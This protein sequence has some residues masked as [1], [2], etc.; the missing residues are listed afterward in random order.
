MEP[1]P[2]VQVP[3][4]DT[5]PVGG[6]NPA[7]PGPPAA[8]PID[9]A[10]PGAVTAAAIVMIVLGVVI[11]LLG[12]LIILSGALIGGAGGGILGNRIADLPAGIGSFLVA[13]GVIVVA[14]GVLDVLSG[15]YILPGRS[16]ARILA[17]IL[18]ALG[19]LLAVAGVFSAE[20]SGAVIWLVLLA[21]HAFV[22]WAM[23][24]NGRWFAGR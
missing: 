8:P 24:A 12:L 15:I 14:F 13:A 9:S 22:L 10:R 1:Q 2:P 18:A 11:G 5:G 17:I 16:W 20:R 21:A 6:W 19:G 7:P 4:P 23:S 3:P